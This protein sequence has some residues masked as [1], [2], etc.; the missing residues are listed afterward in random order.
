MIPDKL[1]LTQSLSLH[2][3]TA[4][5]G[6]EKPYSYAVKDIDIGMA[7]PIGSLPRIIVES[8]WSIPRSSDSASLWLQNAAKTL[9]VLILIEWWN[10]SA[11]TVAGQL[12]VYRRW[13]KKVQ[14]EV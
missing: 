12:R 14:T 9:Q 6:F 10:V 8:R 11:N 1:I 2:F 13:T 7:C 5:T 3:Y 4:T